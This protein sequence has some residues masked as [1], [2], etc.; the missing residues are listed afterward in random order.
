MPAQ[1]ILDNKR[2]YSE[3]FLEKAVVFLNEPAGN[4][5]QAL[6]MINLCVLARISVISRQS[7]GAF[8]INQLL[9]EQEQS[10]V[11]VNSLDYFDPGNGHLHNKGAKLGENLLGK[12]V[13]ACVNL[14]SSCAG[15]SENSVRSL[16][17]ICVPVSLGIIRVQMEKDKA[18]A[19]VLQ[20]LKEEIDKMQRS[21]E[22]TGFNWRLCLEDDVP[23]VSK[24]PAPVSVS[25][26]VDET[27]LKY[28]KLLKWTLVGLSVIIFVFI[29][30]ILTDRI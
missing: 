10:G 6:D 14:I 5:S 22:H 26:G 30:L 28:G 12:Q 11:S 3:N 19:T 4:V 1:L 29:F 15:L 2:Q 25:A 24:S 18:Y 21:L 7:G 20:S 9:R 17:G 23:S 8:T 27:R 16:F 13:D